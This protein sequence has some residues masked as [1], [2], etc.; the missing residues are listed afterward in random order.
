MLIKLLPDQAVKYWEDI[1]VAVE[2]SL[3]PTVGMQ[4]DRMSNILQ[5]LLTD[6]VTAWVS[7]EER[8]DANIVTGIV[9]TTF[10]F[11]KISGTK[12]LLI[13]CVY[14]YSEATKDSWLAGGD[15]LAKFAKSE[16]C[17]RIIG[18]TDVNSIIKYVERIGGDT[19]FTLVSLPMEVL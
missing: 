8:E 14:G 10:T 18:Y 12:S 13:Y 4:S 2:E 1:K 5:A 3:P 17:H 9:L 7:V 6:E 16:G 19:R 15:T 11:D